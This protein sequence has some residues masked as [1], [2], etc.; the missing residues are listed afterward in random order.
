MRRGKVPTQISVCIQEDS[1]ALLR[2]PCCNKLEVSE[3][4]NSGF[5]TGYVRRK[6]EIKLDGGRNDLGQTGALKSK[7]GPH[8]AS[9]LTD[10]PEQTWGLRGTM[11]DPSQG[12]GV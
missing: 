9:G 4:I 11:K 6:I 8:L 7:S 3:W 10:R 12:K 1:T 5:K 2:A